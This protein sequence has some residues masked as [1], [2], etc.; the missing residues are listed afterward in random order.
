M[1]NRFLEL[2]LLVLLL[3]PALSWAQPESID[4]RPR[5]N[6]TQLRHAL[7]GIR[8]RHD[9]PGMAAA[10][11]DREGIRVFAVGE[12]TADGSPVAPESRFHAGQVS[13]LFN[14]LMAATLVA[15]GS[16]SA[17]GELRRLAPEVD[18]HN[19]WSSERPVRV[20]DLLAHR[21]GVGA[22]RF[23]DVYT[24]S[25]EQ[26]LLAGINRA[27]RALRLNNRPGEVERYSVVGHA[28]VA[29][30][31]EKAAG[32]PYEQALERLLFAPMELEATLGRD[33]A[34]TFD[35]TGH[36][37]R[38]SRP[39]PDLALN[40]PPAGDLWI[41]ANDLALVGQL[42]L[43]NGR[44]G[45]RQVVAK[46]ALQWMEAVPADAPA[47]VPGRRRGIDVEEFDGYVF[48]TQT[49]ALPGFLARFAYSRE[50][51]KG[52]LVLLNHGAR[53]AALAEAEALLRGQIIS[54]AA[55]PAVQ[56]VAAEVPN[57]G[58]LVGWY[59][60]VSPQLA[61][62]AL[63][64][65]LDF[66]RAVPCDGLLCFSRL[67]G[68]ERLEAFDANRLRAEGRWH[69]GWNL[70]E[71]ETG[72]LLEEQG[73]LWQPAS[74]GQVFLTVA[75]AL[76]VLTGIVLAFILLPIWTVS[77][78]RRRIGNYHELVP[79]LVPLAAIAVIVAFQVALFTADYPALGKISAPSITILVLS[80]LVPVLAVLSLPATG[81]GFLWGISRRS[82][83]ASAY[84]ALVACVVAIVMAM[85]DLIGFQTWNY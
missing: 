60:N 2:S 30:L 64:L 54:E 13:L 11:F 77:L 29:Y 73:R 48:Y 47:I 18:I 72:F 9:V 14:A 15:D 74:G 50:L 45:E 82:A 62:R 26:P 44:Q 35:S 7:Q 81:A 76:L 41:S 6:D 78:L 22:T 38:P 75:F 57:P 20:E 40:L 53:T 56:A 55:A 66:A 8:L 37:G 68:T 33:S 52:Y 36:V 67:A 1:R 58:K 5:A 43:N 25:A 79:R 80:L 21:A 70:R 17:D 10:V 23:R 85:H 51:D 32:M 34:E 84:L 65:G 63:Y 12:L 27:F 46:K 31:V 69:P 71:T 83:V 16:L 24:E 19:P 59:R 4:T 49:G 39:V 42:L 3:S 61:P 28:V